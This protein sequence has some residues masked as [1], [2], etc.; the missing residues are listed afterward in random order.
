M[1]SQSLSDQKHLLERDAS[2][3]V[4]DQVKNDASSSL[5]VLRDSGSAVTGH[6]AS[7]VS[8]VFDSDADLMRSRVYQPTVR[9]LLRR[10]LRRN[11]AIDLETIR[12]P[13]TSRSS[14]SKTKE[15]ARSKEIDATLKADKKKLRRDRKILLFGSSDSGKEVIL[16]Q[17]EVVPH[18]G[19]TIDER[20]RYLLLI[21]NNTL[22]AIRSFKTYL[23]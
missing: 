4:F 20:E 9:S 22:D 1:Y 6:T 17:I 23:E 7:T 21:Y 19:Y 5:I 13:S 14:S 8:R 12:L 10:A 11:R 2:R 18:G 15:A 3:Q 16:T